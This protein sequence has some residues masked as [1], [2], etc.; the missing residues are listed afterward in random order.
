M[1]Y[2]NQDRGRNSLRQFAKILIYFLPFHGFP[3]CIYEKVVNR[4]QYGN[5]RC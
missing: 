2:N 3:S 5:L 4:T 1:N